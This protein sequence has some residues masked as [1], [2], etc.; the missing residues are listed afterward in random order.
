MLQALRDPVRVFTD[1]V[2]TP[3]TYI[4]FTDGSKY[5]AKNGSTGVIEYSDT[6]ASNVIQ[7]AVNNVNI[8]GGGKIL[9]RRGKYIINRS[10]K[11]LSNVAIEVE[12]GAVFELY[13][14]FL[15]QGL[16]DPAVSDFSLI[17]GR[18]V[19]K[20]DVKMIWFRTT[21]KNI[22]VKGIRLEI[23]P[24]LGSYTASFGIRFE[25]PDNLVIDGITIIGAGSDT[26]HLSGANIV[27]S[28]S[29]LDGLSQFANGIYHTARN[30]FILNNKFIGWKHNGIMNAGTSSN[31]VI[32]GNYFYNCADGIDHDG[33]VENEV[34]AFNV[35]H[36][37][38][39]GGDGSIS[40]TPVSPNIVRNVAIVGNTFRQTNAN[41]YGV[42]IAGSEHVVVEGNVFR[43]SVG[44]ANYFVDIRGSKYVHVRNNAAYMPAYGGITHVVNIVDSVEVYIEGNTFV[45]GPDNR[46]PMV[47][48]YSSSPG[49]TNYLF[50]R[51][52]LFIPNLYG[53]STRES[54]GIKFFDANS[55]NVVIEGNTF[56]FGLKDMI[57]VSPPPGAVI[58]RN[59]GY[60]TE[61][62]GVA[63]IPAG[64]VRVTVSHGLA[65][66]PSKFQVTPLAQPPGKLWVE[67]ITST[68]FDI[69]T[70]TAPTADL[71]VAWHAE[72]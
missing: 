67:N 21:A 38:G 14:P 18:F 7:Y 44:R 5:Y 57:I 29:Y 15:F 69:V 8:L 58:R 26:I 64:S 20:A 46:N 66:T 62:S 30:I 17:G 3:A 35:F 9:I 31:I 41:L 11:P 40:L 72:V 56:D 34:I 52:N 63:T 33:S 53:N 48:V 2:V 60:P 13:Q 36:D 71:K 39:A 28:N 32:V 47:K 65:M 1:F 19:V 6:D 12:D 25:N 54:S 55:R 59:I 23:D 49:S 45:G 70:D 68:S 22:L 4:V 51:S 37:T 10:V 27:V 43:N 24:S 50:I 16:Y 42:F 61:A